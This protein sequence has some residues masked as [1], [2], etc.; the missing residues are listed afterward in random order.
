MGVKIQSYHANNGV[1]K[2]KQWVENCHKKQQE[3]SFVGVGAHHQNGL[4]KNKICILQEMTRTNPLHTRTVWPKEITAH[5]WL[6]PML[7]VNAK[8]NEAQNMQDKQRQSPPQTILKFPS[9]AQ[10]YQ[11]DSLRL[12]HIHLTKRITEHATIP[13]VGNKIK[14]WHISGTIAATWNLC[15]V[16]T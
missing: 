15:V 4:A 12:P 6:Y 9:R 14:Y 5:L 10:L 11:V 2:A 3:L 1:F 7:N 13:Q 16:G 8:L